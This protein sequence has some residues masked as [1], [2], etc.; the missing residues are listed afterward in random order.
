[1]DVLIKDTQMFTCTPW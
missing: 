1:M